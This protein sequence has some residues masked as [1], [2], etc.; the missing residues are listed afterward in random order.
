[1]RSPPT[2]DP[3]RNPLKVLFE[4]NEPGAPVEPEP[5]LV[6]VEL[7]PL[8]LGT[9]EIPDEGQVLESGESIATNSPSIKDPLR[10]KYHAIELREEPLQP[11][12]GVNPVSA[13]RALVSWESVNVLEVV[14]VIP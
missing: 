13:F 4:G 1:V 6:V 2:L 14:G 8:F 7:P 11:R 10:L 5:E 3:D 12:A 9:Y